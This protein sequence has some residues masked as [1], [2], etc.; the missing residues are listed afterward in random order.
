[1]GIY[2]SIIISWFYVLQDFPEILVSGPLP[3]NASMSSL[4]TDI[5]LRVSIT[6]VTTCVVTS[7]SCDIFIIE[8]YKKKSSIVLTNN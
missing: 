8:T 2:V 1:M 4:S 7:Y 5:S 6:Y 3:A